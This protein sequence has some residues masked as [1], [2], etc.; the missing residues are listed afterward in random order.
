MKFEFKVGKTFADYL[1]HKGIEANASD[2]IKAPAFEEYQDG[3]QKALELAFESKA[4][5]EDIL[6][7]TS[8]ISK[9]V[10]KNQ[11]IVLELVRKQ[12]AELLQMKKDGLQSSEKALTLK[13]AVK[14]NLG[15]LSDLANKKTGVELTVKAV[16][17]R[18]SID[19]N[20][21]AFDLPSIGQLA[22]QNV[23]ILNVFPT[24]TVGIGTHSGEIR[25][26]DWDEETTVRAAAMIAEEG[27]FPESTAKFKK[28]VISLK[29][30][31]D[32]LPVTEE[33][34]EDENLFYN[35]LE[36]FL[37]LN[38][39]LK[40]ADNMVNGDGTGNNLTGLITSST[41]YTPVASG[42]T[43]ASI[44]DL[45]VK[46]KEAITKTGG[47]KYMPDVVFMNL[48]TINKYKLKKDANKN[49]V[50]PPFVSADGKVIDGMLVVE[51]NQMADNV[52]V[53]G[54]RKFGTVY[55]MNGVTFAQGEVANQFIEDEMTL[56]VRKRV[57]FLIRN[58]DKN[59][60]Y[61]VTD[62]DAALTTLATTP[63]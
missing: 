61:K 62:I 27:T 54:E 44:Y 19:G 55:A 40:V 25:Y 37:R 60:F 24:Q 21:S 18:A 10:E 48:P 51:V 33:F 22:T 6:A 42:I 11:A 52:L 26:Y 5:K 36:R 35:E 56:K 63:T 49:Y 32:T 30:V 57:L 13:D 23:N 12:G 47:G 15:K 38:V 50:M 46:V 7:I 20:E 31:G 29:K 14:E 39:D 8:E 9:S 59:G 16:S 53:V 17:N 28:Y 45:I 34:F 4:S 58:S 41:A 1:T 2:E 3:M 43:D